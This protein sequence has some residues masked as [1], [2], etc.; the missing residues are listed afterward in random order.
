MPTTDSPVAPV[1][2]LGVTVLGQQVV[3]EMPEVIPRSKGSPGVTTLRQRLRE[4][5]AVAVG[6]LSAQTQPLMPDQQEEQV[7]QPSEPERPPMTSPEG[8]AVAAMKR[9]E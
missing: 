4:G 9:L 2:A 6:R 3:R 8:E 1:V 7:T 5:L